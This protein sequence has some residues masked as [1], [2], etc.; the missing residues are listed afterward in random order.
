MNYSITG[1]LEV[2]DMLDVSVSARVRRKDEF[3]RKV[4]RY[5]RE[6][7]VVPNK[8]RIWVEV[9][10]N[11]YVIIGG[12]YKFDEGKLLHMNRI[13]GEIINTAARESRLDIRGEKHFYPDQEGWELRT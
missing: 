6:L 8:V 13:L 3:Q 7:F 1:P 12:K 9:E 11:G 4:N 5:L 2:R 10:W